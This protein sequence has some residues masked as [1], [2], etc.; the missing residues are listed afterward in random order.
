MTR[1]AATQFFA[2]LRVN[3]LPEARKVSRHLHRPTIRCEQLQDHGHAAACQAG[4]LGQAKELLQPC[5]DR[6]S[7]FSRVVNHGG[8]TRW[9][10]DAIRRRL[11][12]RSLL[13]LSQLR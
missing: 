3:V 13:L 7:G 8:A 12:E 6:R 1:V 9:Q 11:L 10:L 2:D 4:D 5:G